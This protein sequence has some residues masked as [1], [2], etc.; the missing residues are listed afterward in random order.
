MPVQLASIRCW[1]LSSKTTPF[2]VPLDSVALSR[3]SDLTTSYGGSSSEKKEVRE[4]SNRTC[5]T[6]RSKTSKLGCNSLPASLCR[7]SGNRGNSW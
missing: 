2:P 4:I 6:S 5:L 7:Q 1:G 3:S